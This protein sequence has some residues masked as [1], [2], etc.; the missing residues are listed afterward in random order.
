M[1]KAGALLGLG[2]HAVKKDLK[3]FKEMIE[4]RHTESGSWRGDV[5]N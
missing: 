3:N 2:Q 5:Q 4:K 1:E